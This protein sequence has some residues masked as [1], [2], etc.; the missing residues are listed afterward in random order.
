MALETDYTTYNGREMK[1]Q[2]AR[3]E[4]LVA[5]KNGVEI[6]LSFYLNRE[7]SLNNPPYEIVTIQRECD[8]VMMEGINPMEEA[9]RFV[10]EEFTESLD[11]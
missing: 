2:Y 6:E 8:F 11:V 9:Y 5:D 10:K 3:I 7:D 4:R 1:K